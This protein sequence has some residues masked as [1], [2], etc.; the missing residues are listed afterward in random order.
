MPVKNP[1]AAFRSECQ[2][3]LAIAF[4]KLFPEIYIADWKL[5][6]PPN[7]SFGQL[8]SSLCFELAKQMRQRPDGL[9]EKLSAA[10]DV[11]HFSLIEKVAPLA[12]YVNFNV[13]FAKFSTLTLES[14][15]EHGSNYGLLKTREPLRIIIEHTSAN[16]AHPIHIG[17][18]RNPVLGDTLARL[19]KSRGHRVDIHFYIDDVGRQSSVM[20]YGY[21]KLGK[22][23]PES[24]PDHYIGQIYTI[25]SCLVEINRLKKELEQA[26][27]VSSEDGIKEITKKLDDWVSVAAELQGKYPELFE[28]LLVKVNADENSETAIKILNQAYEI[29]DPKAKRLV[30]TASELC[31]EGFK[32]TL[33]KID[34]SIDSWDWESDLVSSGRVVSVLQKLK[35]SKYTFSESGVYEFDAGRVIEDLDL[36]KKLNLRQNQEIPPLTLIRADGTTLYT[37]RDIAYTLQKFEKAEKVI[38]VIGMEQSL[39]QLQL[40]IALYALGYDRFADSLVHFAYNLV[41]LPDYKM[42]ARRGHYVMLDDVVDEAINRAYEEVSK[43][44]GQL[45]E[46]EK[47]EIATFV[48]TGAVRYALVEVDSTKPVVFTWDRVL[49]FEKNSAPYVQ[50]THARACSILRKAASQ[51]SDPAYDLLT[52]KLEKEI[53]LQIASFPDTFEDATENLKPHLIADYANSLADKFNAFYGAFPVIKAEPRK[54]SDARLSLTE[55]TKTVLGTSLGLIGIFAPEKM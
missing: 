5:E 47:R 53:I 32:Q 28:K 4:K 3:S 1:F 44:S 39:A 45:T 19:L 36:R 41:T 13:N 55:A 22:P 40:K 37:T 6:K 52:E 26:K 29:G 27:K 12:G 18:A 16:P 17:T 24:K 46:E 8:A 51:P 34:V 33:K 49:N 10:T 23:K 9:A 54:L 35:T 15:T 20:A 38:N 43:R 48:G 30:R 14:T 50:Y 31:I 21:D 25:T 2:T 11:T 7:Q 42:S